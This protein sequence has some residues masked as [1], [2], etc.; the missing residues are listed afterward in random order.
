MDKN[1]IRTDINC[2]N[3][4]KNFI[5]QIDFALDGN[6]IVNCPHCNHEHFREIKGGKVTDIRW[7]SQ[8][9]QIKIPP[10]CVWKSDKAPIVASTAA[11]HIRELWLNKLDSGL[12]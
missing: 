3:C 7:N 11:S 1:P 10:Q 6:H 12:V 8:S 2:T 4:N 9:N 5:A